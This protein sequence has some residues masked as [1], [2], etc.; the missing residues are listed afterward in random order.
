MRIGDSDI[1]FSSILLMKS[2]KLHFSSSIS[3]FYQ[4]PMRQGCKD[5]N[6]KNNALISILKMDNGMQIYHPLLF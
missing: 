5:F 6:V 3:Q 2:V 4:L 1:V